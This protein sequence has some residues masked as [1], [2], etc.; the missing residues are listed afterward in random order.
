MAFPYPAVQYI[1]L[2]ITNLR[3]GQLP[4]ADPATPQTGAWKLTAGNELITWESSLKRDYGLSFSGEFAIEEIY[5]G[6][7]CPFLA[8][9]HKVAIAK[10]RGFY[11]TMLGGY[12]PGQ[13]QLFTVPT[14]R[15]YKSKL[16]IQLFDQDSGQ[17]LL[18]QNLFWPPGPLPS[19]KTKNPGQP[20]LDSNQVKSG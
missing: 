12:A 11:I 17:R 3:Q 5:A 7:V 19:P 9:N 14:R 15:L 20:Q 18:Q 2:P 6:N 10:Y 1:P 13:Y 4:R 8:I 16:V